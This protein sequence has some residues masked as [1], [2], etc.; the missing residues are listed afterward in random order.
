MRVHADS[1]KNR[2]PAWL[3]RKN[4]VPECIIVMLSVRLGLSHGDAWPLDAQGVI[5]D[6]CS[7]SGCGGGYGVKQSS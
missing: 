2:E 3:F 1:L 4:E 6:R 7:G 5:G